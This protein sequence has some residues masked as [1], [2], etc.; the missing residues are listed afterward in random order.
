M[1]RM[2]GL[3]VFKAGIESELMVGTVYFKHL[4][5]RGIQEEIIPTQNKSILAEP[6]PNEKC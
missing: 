1:I 2:G 4:F 5:F 6:R 3:P